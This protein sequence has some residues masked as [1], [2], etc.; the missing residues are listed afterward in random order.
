MAD[1]D[2]IKPFGDAF[3]LFLSSENLERTYNEKKVIAEWSKIIG[4]PIAKRTTN[5]F[6]HQKVL[7]VTL[8]SAPLKQELIHSREKIIDLIAERIAPNV[9]EDI[10]FK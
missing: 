6:I 4:E 8:N 7:H 3:K 1:E 9:I 10:R 2:S 5:L